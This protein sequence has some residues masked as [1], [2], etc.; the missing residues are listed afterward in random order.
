MEKRARVPGEHEV[1]PMT[2]EAKLCSPWLGSQH[3]RLIKEA[4]MS[5]GDEGAGRPRGIAKS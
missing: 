2:D 1:P 3:D 4:S 5:G